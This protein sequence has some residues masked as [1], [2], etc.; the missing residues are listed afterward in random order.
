MAVEAKDGP[1][2][3][4]RV[5][6]RRTDVWWC[7]PLV[8][9]VVLTAFVAYGLYITF[10]DRN[11]FWEPY[12]SPFFSPCLT[13][14]CPASVQ[15]QSWPVGAV[16]PA[17]IV[18]V[19][20][21]GFRATC[22]YYRK[23]Y[24]RA[25]WLSPPACAVAEPHRR[26]TGE[27]RFPLVLQ[28]VHRSFFY[29]GVLFAA[30]LTYDVVIAFRDHQGHWGHAG[31]GTLVLLINAVLIW[32]YTLGCHSCRHLTAGRINHFSRHPV[33]YRWWTFVSVLNARHAQWAWASLVWIA[34][35][36]VYIRMIAGG[37]INDVQFF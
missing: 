1:R 7:Q 2:A 9:F 21:L 22:Y 6:T 12:L 23:A 13:D 10:V 34:L 32:G 29:F 3:D 5:R 28:N 33:R 11:Y 26:Y 35:S 36:D 15:W 31:L 20:P 27:T 18:L 14:S 24:Y 4:T 17:L 16:S 19:F 37:V 25:F 30:I 8:T